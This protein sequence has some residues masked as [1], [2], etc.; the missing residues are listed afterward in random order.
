MEEPTP[1]A[2]A[3]ERQGAEQLRD[4]EEKRQRECLAFQHELKQNQEKAAALVRERDQLFQ[5]ISQLQNQFKALMQSK[6]W[7]LGHC[8]VSLFTLSMFKKNFTMA[9]DHIKRIF[10]KVDDFK[11]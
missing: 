5:W 1:G 4:L 8:L 10:N 11:S 9:T 3:A 7:R 6:R 2:E